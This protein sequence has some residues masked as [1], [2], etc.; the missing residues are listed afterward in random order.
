MSYTAASKLQDAYLWNSGTA[1][2]DKAAK[3]YSITYSKAP[4]RIPNSKLQSC[5]GLHRPLSQCTCRRQGTHAMFR[6]VMLTNVCGKL[7]FAENDS[8]FGATAERCAISRIR[9]FYAVV[10]LLF[11]RHVHC[12][13]G[14]IPSRLESGIS[15]LSTPLYSS[16]YA[17][18][19]PPTRSIVPSVHSSS[20]Q[21][22]LWPL[23]QMVV[24]LKAVPNKSTRSPIHA[25]FVQVDA[26]SWS[27]RH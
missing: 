8:T 5:Q 24:V 26:T 2:A 3:T 11:I 6:L 1:S 10:V 18:S 21:A 7:A 14:E 27:M 15:G 12:T 19:V 17:P 20:T 13:G 23:L 4:T 16:K 22:P 25:L 9:G